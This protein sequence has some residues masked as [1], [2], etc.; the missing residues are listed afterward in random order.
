MP[1]F[2]YRCSTCGT[3]YEELVFGDRDRTIPCLSCGSK[4]TEKIP[5]VIGRVALSGSTDT[6]CGSTCS[7]SPA[8]A[9]GGG[10]CPHAH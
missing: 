5:S 1:I 10:C 6:P 9:A 7:S 2:E 4:Q 3:V 8:C